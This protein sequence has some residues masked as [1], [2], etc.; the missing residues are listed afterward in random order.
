MN[1]QCDPGFGA[2]LLGFN[3][4][5]VVY[6]QSISDDIE[7]EYAMEYTRMLRNRAKGV[8]VSPPRYPGLFEPN[9]NLIG[10]TLERMCEKYFPSKSSALVRSDPPLLAKTDP[11]FK[12]L[13]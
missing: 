2:S 1:R 11:P 5:A 4:E 12:K 8:E 3:G 6:C 7:H 13:S 10:S 9:R